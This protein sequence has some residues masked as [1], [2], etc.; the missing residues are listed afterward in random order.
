MTQL[1]LTKPD[2]AS[3]HG[4]DPRDTAMNFAGA[5]HHNF[6]REHLHK[7]TKAIIGVG[8][9][10]VLSILLYEFKGKVPDPRSTSAMPTEQHQSFAANQPN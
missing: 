9:L 8:V 7:P 1:P 5:Q 3:R 4:Q 2:H 10:V 6:G